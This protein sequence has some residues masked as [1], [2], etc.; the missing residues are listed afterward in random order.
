MPAQRQVSGVCAFGADVLYW[1]KMMQNDFQFC[2]QCGGKQVRN[3]RM[4]EWVCAD[5]GKLTV[6]GSLEDKEFTIASIEA[7]SYTFTNL[8]FTRL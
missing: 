8:K 3:V 1:Q 7:Y 4:R 2:P 5:C 6:T